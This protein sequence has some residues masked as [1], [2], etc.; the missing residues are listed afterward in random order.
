MTRKI[1]MTFECNQDWEQMKISGH[2]R[3]CELCRKTVYDFSN[4]SI[5]DV[6]NV[7][8]GELCGMF[9][10][11]QIESDLRPIEV[12]FSLK[13]A[14][15]TIGTFLGLELS[16][17]HGQDLD[18]G[19]RIEN[20]VSDLNKADTA[21]TIKTQ[22]EDFK[23]NGLGDCENVKRPMRSRYYFSKRFPFIVKRRVRTVARYRI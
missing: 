4:K 9:L 1:E 6:V 17:V 10:A 3:H 21:R 2:G 20:V 16:Q 5:D 8:S 14:L 19:H 7:S 22:S 18:Q 23:A 11:E 15:L 13:T 12:P